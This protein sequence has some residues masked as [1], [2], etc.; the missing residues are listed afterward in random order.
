[1]KHRTLIRAAAAAS[2]AVFGA[3]AAFATMAPPEVAAKLAPTALVESLPIP[4]E[5]LLPPPASYIREER[6]QRGD[7]IAAFLARL[8][9][10]PAHIDKLARVRMLHNL[11]PG[12]HVGAEVSADGTPLSLNFLNG[13]D[14]LV[15]I[16]RE[17]EAYRVTEERASFETRVVM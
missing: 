1:M 3:V 6:F 4:P 13:R 11:R 10:A 7:T 14:T 5:A 2:L 12:F 16:A 9:I 8:G 17:G 15:Q